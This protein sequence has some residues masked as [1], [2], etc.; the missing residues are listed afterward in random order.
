MSL[1]RHWCLIIVRLAILSSVSADICNVQ[2]HSPF[3]VIDGNVEDI[4]TIEKS[5]KCDETPELDI[6]NCAAKCLGREKD[7]TGCPGFLVL[8]IPRKETNAPCVV[9]P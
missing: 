3:K 1:Q 4:N 8:W 5:F 7:G 2:P 6:Q 9:Y